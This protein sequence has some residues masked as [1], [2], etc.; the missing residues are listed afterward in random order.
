VLDHP[1]DIRRVMDVIRANTNIKENLVA[2]LA[3]LIKNRS[4]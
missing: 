1:T 2:R 4:L 3:L